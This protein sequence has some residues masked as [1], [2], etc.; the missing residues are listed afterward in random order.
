MSPSPSPTLNAAGERVRKRGA[1]S[2]A[3]AATKHSMSKPVPTQSSESARRGW[4]GLKKP[5]GTGPVT[6]VTGLTGPARFR[7]RAVRNRV[8]FK[9]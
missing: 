6:V 8:K 5:V 7:I 9:F 2:S 3:P 4:G 1:A